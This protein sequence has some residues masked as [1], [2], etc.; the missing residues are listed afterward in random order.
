MNDMQNGKGFS[1]SKSGEVY[2][3]THK[4]NEK[5]G[6]AIVKTLRKG[7]R[8]EV[9][10]TIYSGSRLDNQAHGK[11][12]RLESNGDYFSGTWHHAKMRGESF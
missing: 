3:G 11:G 10:V 4:D 1:I 8:G 12:I 2:H 7:M 9:M 5:C 6:D